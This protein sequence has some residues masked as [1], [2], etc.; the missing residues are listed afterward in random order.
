[1]SGLSHRLGFCS[2]MYDISYCAVVTINEM[3]PETELDRSRLW[4]NY[5]RSSR[6]A[7]GQNC[8]CVLDEFPK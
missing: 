6:H 3:S 1:M 5:A 4:S 8:P 2:A 7:D